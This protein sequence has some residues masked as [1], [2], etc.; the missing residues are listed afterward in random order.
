MKSQCKMANRTVVGPHPYARAKT[1]SNVQRQAPASVETLPVEQLRLEFDVVEHLQVQWAIEDRAR[2]IWLASGCALGSALSD[3]LKA[4]AEVLLEFVKARTKGQ[5]VSPAPK[6]RRS[7]AGGAW[8]LLPANLPAQAALS[9]LK[10]T[11]AI[12]HL[13]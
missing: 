11:S 10:S 13:L 3:W 5:L 7:R 6:R 4:E 8:S 12:Q 9:K 1:L 2:Q